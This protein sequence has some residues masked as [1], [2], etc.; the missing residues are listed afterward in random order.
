MSTDLKSKMSNNSNNNSNNN[1]EE[2]ENSVETNDDN[3]SNLKIKQRVRCDVCGKCYSSKS[4]LTKH[5]EI[6]NPK[7]PQCPKCDRKFRNDMSLQQHLKSHEKSFTTFG[8]KNIF[9]FF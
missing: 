2:N 6:H 9:A 5:M 3:S 4:Y 1:S 7:A 8:K